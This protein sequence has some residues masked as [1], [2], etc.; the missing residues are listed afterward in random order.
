[1]AFSYCKDIS[2]TVID[3]YIYSFGPITFQDGGSGYQTKKRPFFFLFGHSISF[4]NVSPIP[5]VHLMHIFFNLLLN[6]REAVGL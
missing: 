5:S 3:L 6:T 2:T 1:M 4:G